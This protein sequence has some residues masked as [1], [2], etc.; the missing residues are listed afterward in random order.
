MTANDQSARRARPTPARSDPGAASKT[1]QVLPEGGPLK[2]SP[3]ERHVTGSVPTGAPPV[4]APSR[5]THVDLRTHRRT[6]ICV[7]RPRSLTS[8]PPPVMEATSWGWLAALASAGRRV[9]AGRRDRQPMGHPRWRSRL[10]FAAATSPRFDRGSAGLLP[11]GRMDSSRQP[12][13]SRPGQ[14]GRASTVS[15]DHP[16]L[17][18][19]VDVPAVACRKSQS[20]AGPTVVIRGSGP[21]RCHWCEVRFEPSQTRAS[22]VDVGQDGAFVQPEACRS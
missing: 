20:A 16:T 3:S 2:D 15:V 10:P 14:R 4:R 5:G 21:G 8:V 12:D 19:G 18:R 6:E 13:P 9:G 7:H 11:E 17:L 22:R 1:L